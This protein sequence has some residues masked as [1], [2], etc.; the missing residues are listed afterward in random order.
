MGR[1]GWFAL[2][3]VLVL[4]WAGSATAGGAAPTTELV[5]GTFSGKSSPPHSVFC[6]GTD[7]KYLDQRFVARGTERSS[8]SR[9]SGKFIDHTRILVNLPEGVGR[10]KGSVVLEDPDTGTVK[11]RF[12]FYGVGRNHP[13]GSVTLKGMEIGTLADGSVIFLNS[14]DVGKPDGTFS[15]EFGKKAGPVDLSVIQKGSCT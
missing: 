10:A 12:T 13:D 8:D 3:G 7:G 11:A 9:L 4:G 6:K 1:F 15:G 5:S 14:T 2:I